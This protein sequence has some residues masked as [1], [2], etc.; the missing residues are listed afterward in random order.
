M[1]LQLS[2]CISPFPW[3]LQAFYPM[4]KC[5]RQVIKDNGMSDKITVLPKRSTGLTVGPGTVH[6]VN[7]IPKPNRKCSSL[8]VV[9]IMLLFQEKLILSNRIMTN[10]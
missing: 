8:D 10:A 2:S 7:L 1:V 9:I 5:A 6:D 3:F 4:A